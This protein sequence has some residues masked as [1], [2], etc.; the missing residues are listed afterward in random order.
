[1]V[2]KMQKLIEEC[3]LRNYSK[4]TIETYVHYNQHFLKLVKKKPLEVTQQ[5]IR[6][7]LGVLIRWNRKPAT[8]NLAH[9]ALI[10]YYSQILKRKFYDIPFQKNP[11]TVKDT[12]TKNEI[13]N[14][15]EVTPNLKHKLMI[16]MLYAT[17][18]RVSE[19]IKIRVSDIDFSRKLLLVKEGKGNRDRY[20]I[21]S[22]KVIDKLQE[23]LK[24][25][26]NE[27]NYLFE[28]SNGHLTSATVQ[29]VLK[30]A[31]KKAKITKNVTPHVLRHSFATHL[32][33]SGIQDADIQ[34]LLGHKDLK[35]T[36]T[37]A[38]VSVEHL[39]RIRS[40]DD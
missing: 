9:N 33:D 7:Y 26:K 18:V 13:K 8:V 10:F 11:E 23:H 37:Y 2:I 34:K 3:T 20:T 1:M 35:T 25:R 32:R 17:G 31:R 38:K 6:W 12:L 4:R 16:S 27:S 19:L 29:A 39:R 14:L 40:P 15:I 21:L 24:I 30:N 28:T 36:Q 22:D 5:D